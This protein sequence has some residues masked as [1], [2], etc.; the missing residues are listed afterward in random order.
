ME[1]ER[2][3]LSTSVVLSGEAETL[4]YSNYTLVTSDAASLAVAEKY[5][6][7]VNIKTELLA[8]DLAQNLEVQL[9]QSQSLDLIIASDLFIPPVDP[10]ILFDTL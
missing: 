7:A 6:R 1:F 10:R 4:G 9:K 2:Q 8:L 3:N 5:T